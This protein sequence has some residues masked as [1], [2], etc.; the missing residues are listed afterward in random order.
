MS[1]GFLKIS[2]LGR[3]SHVASSE[4]PAIFYFLRLRPIK[5]KKTSRICSELIV[6]FFILLTFVPKKITAK[7]GE[8]F[9]F[10]Y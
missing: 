7:A 10:E 1:V 6:L 2:Q 5:Q 3:F 8:V 9:H 4:N